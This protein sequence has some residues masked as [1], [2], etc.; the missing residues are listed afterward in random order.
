MK[1]GIVSAILDG[2]TFEEMIDTV[3]ELGFSCV[4]TAC[5]PFKVLWDLSLCQPLSPGAT[6]LSPERGM[7]RA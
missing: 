4:E 5:W 3:S 6:H 7:G 2:W 1:L